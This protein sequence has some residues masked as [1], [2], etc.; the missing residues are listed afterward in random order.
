MRTGAV[1]EL[2]EMEIREASLRNPSRN[3][4]LY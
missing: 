1:K 2:V 3:N 4:P